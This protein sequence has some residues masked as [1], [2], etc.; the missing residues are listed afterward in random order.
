MEKKKKNTK[1]AGEEELKAARDNSTAVINKEKRD[2]IQEPTPVEPPS[3]GGPQ[4][5]INE[6]VT[7]ASITQAVS[8]LQAQFRPFQKPLS[9]KERKRL[10]GTSYKSRSF[11]EQAYANIKANPNLVPNYIDMAQFEAD[12][13]AF[14]KKS[15]LD[16]IL[17]Q[18]EREVSDS[19]LSDGDKVRRIAL[20]YY[21]NLKTLARGGVPGAE[22]A[23]EA[24]EKYFKSRKRKTEKP[25]QK[26]VM[27]DA[28]ALLE[29]KKEGKVVISNELPVTTGNKSEVVSEVHS[30]HVSSEKTSGTDMKD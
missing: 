6:A 5:P 3:T 2:E 29:G 19:E 25:T 7:V 30:K 13:E 9:P 20:L 11:V 10:M 28:R 14:E 18:F 22:A 21:N 24:L 27:R 12:M 16:E 17:K 1:A 23:L 26:E 4:P 8:N 15:Y